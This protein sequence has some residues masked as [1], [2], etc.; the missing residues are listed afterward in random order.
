MSICDL[1]DVPGP[2][3]TPEYCPQSS[4]LFFLWELRM[5]LALELGF[6]EI[7]EPQNVSLKILVAA[8]ISLGVADYLICF[9]D[10]TLVSIYLENHP[11]P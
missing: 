3:R 10:L 6:P 8:S 7:W 5:I 2:S 9:P 4:W 1:W 11:F